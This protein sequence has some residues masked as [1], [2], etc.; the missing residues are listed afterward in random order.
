MNG[1]GALRVVD[2]MPTDES[3]LQSG[4]IKLDDIWQLVGLYQVVKFISEL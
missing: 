3:H 2:D 1:L 4:G